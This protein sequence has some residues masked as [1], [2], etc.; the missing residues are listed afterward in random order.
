MCGL[1]STYNLFLKSTH[2]A[3]SSAYTSAR[4][5]SYVAYTGKMLPTSVPMSTL[6]HQHTLSSQKPELFSFLLVVVVFNTNLITFKSFN[7]FL[8]PLKLI[9]NSRPR[10]KRHFRIRLLFPMPTFTKGLFSLFLMPSFGP[11]LGY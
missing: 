2:I 6:T 10:S 11:R 5:P 9:S 7:N 8:L 3:A 4:V 1:S